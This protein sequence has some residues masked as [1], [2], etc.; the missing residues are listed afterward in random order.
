MRTRPLL[1]GAGLTLAVTLTY[2]GMMHN[3]VVLDD[4]WVTVKNPYIQHWGGI[5]TLFTKDVWMG[6]AAG[7]R[8]S[9]YRPLFMT[10][11]LPNRLLLGNTAESYHVGNLLLHAAAV[12]L[13]VRLLGM[14]LAGKRS[15]LAWMG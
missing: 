9:F 7:E 2:W 1:L 3:E 5:V 15:W 12:L 4:P 11:F 14:L 6:T 10:S 13:L 8:S